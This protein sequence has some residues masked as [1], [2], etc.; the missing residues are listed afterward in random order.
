MVVLKVIF[1]RLIL[2]ERNDV[3]MVIRGFMMY[4]RG[5]IMVFCL[6]VEYLFMSYGMVC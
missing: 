5:F 4:M 6:G 1:M 2:V 3:L